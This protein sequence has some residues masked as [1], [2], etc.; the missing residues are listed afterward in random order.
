[1]I[2][3][4]FRQHMKCMFY[5]LRFL[6]ED[7]KKIVWLKGLRHTYTVESF[8]LPNKKLFRYFWHRLHN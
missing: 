7:I 8:N 5:Q 6:T 1:M 2:Q 3:I 4:Q